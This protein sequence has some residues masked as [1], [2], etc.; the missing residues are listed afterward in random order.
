MN[1][2][3]LEDFNASMSLSGDLSRPGFHAGPSHVHRHSREFPPLVE[4]GAS[5]TESYLSAGSLLHGRGDG[6][7]YEPS[8]EEAAPK[9][10]V[11][12]E[13]TKASDLSREPTSFLHPSCRL[14]GTGR[15]P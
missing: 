8:S 11:N 9:V 4:Y 2:N 3:S 15:S 7:A 12:T 5:M 1:H 13:G 14:A 10:K 6:A